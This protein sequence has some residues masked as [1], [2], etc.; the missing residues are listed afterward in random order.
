MSKP[1][2]NL[3]WREKLAL[4][5]ITGAISGAVRAIVAWTLQH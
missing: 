5:T 2:T 4:A 1:P 3:T